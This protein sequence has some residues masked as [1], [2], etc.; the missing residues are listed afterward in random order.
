MLRS[1]QHLTSSQG[2]KK[3]TVAIENIEKKELDEQLKK[4]RENGKAAGSTASGAANAL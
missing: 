4:L 1:F 2:K 3:L